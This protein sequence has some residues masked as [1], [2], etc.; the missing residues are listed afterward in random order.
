[1]RRHG[2]PGNFHH[3]WG[4]VIDRQRHPIIAR[5]ICRLLA[6]QPAEEVD[7]EAFVHIADGR[8]LWPAIRPERGNRHDPVLVQQ[9]QDLFSDLL[10]HLPSP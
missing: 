6:V 2:Q 9:L 5:E 10:A 7:G 4:I 3:L 1:V 8:R